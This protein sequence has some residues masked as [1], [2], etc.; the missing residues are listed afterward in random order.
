[1]SDPKIAGREE[2]LAARHELLA[3]EKELFRHRDEVNAARRSL[4]MVEITEDYTLDGPEGKVTLT[5]LFDGRS[6]LIVYHAMFDPDDDA[7]CPAC[8]FWMDGVGDLTHLY[9][10]D[11]TLVFASIAPLEKLEAYQKRMGWDLPWYSSHGSSFNYDFHVT[12]DAD[13]APVE[14]NYK[15]YDELVKDDPGWEGF[16]GSETGISAFLRQGDR[17]FHTYSC[18]GR[19]IDLVNATYNW[20]DLTARGRQEHFEKPDGRSDAG[21]ME[22]LRRKDEYDPEVIAGAKS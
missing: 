6:Q 21:S 13:V 20:L 4:P 19:G 17:I 10:R 1:M 16:A 8:S 15:T 7:L 14:W 18:Y 12:L 5:E 22:W 2:W 3:K 11:T 9:A